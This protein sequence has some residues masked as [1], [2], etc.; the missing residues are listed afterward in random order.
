LSSDKTVTCF[1]VK[2]LTLGL[3]VQDFTVSSL[4]AMSNIYMVEVQKVRY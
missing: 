1:S 4:H 2:F 3:E